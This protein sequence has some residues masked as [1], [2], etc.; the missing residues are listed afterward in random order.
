MV[1]VL[2]ETTECLGD[3]VHHGRLL[4]N[5]EQLLRRGVGG[6]EA[7]HGELLGETTVLKRRSR[8]DRFR[9]RSLFTTRTSHRSRQAIRENFFQRSRRFHRCSRTRR[10][11]A[12]AH[13]HARTHTR[14]CVGTRTRAHTC[15][16]TRARRGERIAALALAT[17]IGWH[18]SLRRSQSLTAIALQQWLARNDHRPCRSR[19]AGEQRERA[20]SV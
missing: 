9:C 4:S 16:R 7:N 1:V 18:A 6:G 2:R 13:A 3:V 10:M 12:C 5:H 20:A 8:C 15:T 19:R 14:V 17:R 11:C